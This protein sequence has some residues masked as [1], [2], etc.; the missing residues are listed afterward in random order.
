M[1]KWCRVEGYVDGDPDLLMKLEQAFRRGNP[2]QTI[3]P[4]DEEAL[5]NN[6]DAIV[7]A[8]N[9]LWGTEWDVEDSADLIELGEDGLD[10]AFVTAWEPPIGFFRKLT[11][12]GLGMSFI[13]GAEDEFFG[14]Y[15]NG[16]LLDS[17]DTKGLSRDELDAIKQAEE[18]IR[19]YFESDD[20]DA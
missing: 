5:G 9:I 7:E 6:S 14:L 3:L 18:S 8:R 2:F 19:T 1:P 15:E 16:K 12:L 11:E 17:R 10:L 13:Y 20:Y 4:I